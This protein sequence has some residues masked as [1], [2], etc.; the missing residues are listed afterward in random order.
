MSFSEAVL[1]GLIAGFL[2]VFSIKLFDKLKI[3]DPVGAISVHLVCGVWGTLAVGAFGNLASF[4]QLLSQFKGVLSIALV[5]FG[6]SWILFKLI[7][8]FMGLR[9]SKQEE[10]EGLD[11]GEHDESAYCFSP[12][13]VFSLH[14]EVI[15]KDLFLEEKSPLSIK[16]LNTI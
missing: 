15:R 1:I 14:G 2:V 12:E 7:D 11:L 9:V 6:A 8:F 16:V 4:R 10:E 13:S 5:T 3:D